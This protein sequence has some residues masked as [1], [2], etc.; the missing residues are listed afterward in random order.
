MAEGA[1]SGMLEVTVVSPARQLYQGEAQWVTAP[2]ADGQFGIRPRH[3]DLVAALGAGPLRIGL[4][5]GQV[6]RYAVKGGFLKVGSNK[7]TI[8]VDR[9]VTEADVNA[10]EARHDLEET[11]AELKHPKTDEEFAALLEQRAWS[12]TRLKLAGS[13]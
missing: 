13:S 2:G 10:G 4:P 1:S 8:L 11:L 6:Q 12:E 9:A 5:G 7:V 3:A